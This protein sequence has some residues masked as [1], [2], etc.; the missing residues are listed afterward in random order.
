M[1]IRDRNN[2]KINLVDVP[3]IFD[4]VGEC[5][6]ALSVCESALIVV[7]SSAG[8][9][10]G[11]K[12]AMF[13]AKDKAKI[14]YI[15]GLDN[16][17]S[18]YATKLQQL[19][20]TYGK[21]IAP[22]QVPIMDNNKMVGYVNV[23]K[24]EGR[25]FDGEQTKATDIPIELMEQVRP[26]KEMIDEAVANTSDE[27]L[28]KY[29]N[30]EPFTKEEISWALRKGVMAVSYTHL[31]VYKRQVLH[32]GC[33]DGFQILLSLIHISSRSNIQHLY[34]MVTIPFHGYT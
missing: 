10:A 7:P 16:P 5:E 26:I 30:E 9:S 2:C 15:N 11:T 23:A 25:I 27:L 32:R 3:G 13:R 34:I 22:I 28:E 20:D 12:Q 19:K 29:I 1:C 6:A 8:I 18:D 33:H 4:F 21:A 14:I 24:M 31:D 17:S